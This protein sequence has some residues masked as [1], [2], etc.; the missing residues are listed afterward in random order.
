MLK[1]SIASQV[2]G[3]MHNRA[4]KFGKTLTNQIMIHV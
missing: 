4:N 3:K 2:T 1:Q